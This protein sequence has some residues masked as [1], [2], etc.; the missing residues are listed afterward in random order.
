MHVPVITE[1][2]V[3]VCVQPCQP[4][5]RSALIMVSI[6]SGEIKRPVV[7]ITLNTHL[8]QYL[9]KIVSVVIETIK[10]LT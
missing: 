3:S 5:L 6:S 10:S 7:S 9:V 1:E 8:L 4:T 2:T